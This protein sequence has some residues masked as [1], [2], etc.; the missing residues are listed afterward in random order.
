MTILN[1][2]SD[3]LPP[4]LISLAITVAKEKEVVRENLI[5]MCSP[6][7]FFTTNETDTDN[8]SSAR[9]RATLNRW[10]S[11]GFFDDSDGKI[12]LK[13]PPKRGELLEKYSLRLPEICCDLLFQREVALPLWGSDGVVSEENT[14]R[15]ADLC[16]G[17]AWCLAQDIYTM[18]SVYSEVED[19]IRS[20]VEAGRFI[21]LNDTRW[22]GLRTWARY[23]GFATGND[24][25]FLFDPTLI[26]RSQ[27]K[28]V[29]KENESLPAAEFVSRISA[30]LP[31]L[32]RGFYRIE[33]ERALKKETWLQPAPDHLSSS[34]SF[35]L[36]RLQ[37]QGVIA[38]E[39]MA[40]A[41]AR[42]ALTGQSGRTWEDF[43]HVR[44]LKGIA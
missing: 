23:L 16:R 42:I 24:S 25:G 14:G 7:S 26:V 31:V 27:L 40:D 2:Q 44:L 39:S 13:F 43:T 3:G 17:L 19:V 15:S 37:K 11:F 33:V 20:Q 28:D 36:R 8:A 38:F 4:I 9:L 12:K 41:G 5:E 34:L 30:R 35:A 18:P 29:M 10:I 6:P 32:D 1:L 22:G 21:I